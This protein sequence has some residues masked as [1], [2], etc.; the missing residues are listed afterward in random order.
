[1][2]Q[3]FAEN[4]RIHCFGRLPN[5][6][7]DRPRSVASSLHCIIVSIA[8]QRRDPEGRRLVRLPGEYESEDQQQKLS[9]SHRVRS[10]RS[11]RADGGE[12]REAARLTR[13]ARSSHSANSRISSQRRSDGFLTCYYIILYLIITS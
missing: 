4:K 2:L 6:I 5:W 7:K 12:H 8:D 13:T 10:P 11:P 3:V 1:M 9:A